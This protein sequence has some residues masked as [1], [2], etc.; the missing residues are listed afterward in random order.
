MERG[1]GV[2]W[3]FTIH[4][5]LDKN[6]NEKKGQV[7]FDNEGKRHLV[8][9]AWPGTMVYIH[10]HSDLGSGGWAM[11]TEVSV[12]DLQGYPNVVEVIYPYGRCATVDEFMITEVRK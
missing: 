8:K 3:V 12:K 9:E 5:C 11:V 7:M 6:K 2:P 4:R 1:P 10:P